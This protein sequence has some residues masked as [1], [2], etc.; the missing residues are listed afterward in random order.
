LATWMMH[1]IQLCVSLRLCARFG[2]L[3]ACLL[4]ISK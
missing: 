3:L 2:W 4:A 1:T